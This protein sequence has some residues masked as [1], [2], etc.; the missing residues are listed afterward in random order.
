MK[1]RIRPYYFTLGD[2]HTEL[3][4]I[5]YKFHWWESWKVI[6]GND[7]PIFFKSKEEAMGYLNFTKDK[8][9]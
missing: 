8:S 6:K 7:N 1:I 2:M 5:M 9:K 3:H 4:I